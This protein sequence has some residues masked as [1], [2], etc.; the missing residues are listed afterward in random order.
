M[1][2]VTDSSFNVP[3]APSLNVAEVIEEPVEEQTASLAVTPVANNVDSFAQV[4]EED[5]SIS[6]SDEG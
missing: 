3:S 6:S 2:D 4:N 1:P 5:A